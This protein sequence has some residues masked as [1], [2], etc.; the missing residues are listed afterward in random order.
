M[1]ASSDNK[2]NQDLARD[3]TDWAEDRTLM[4]NE[5]T[6]SSWVGTGLG[7]VGVAI[8]LKAVFGEFEPTWAAKAVA[9]LFLLAAIAIF[10][11]ARRQALKTFARLNNNDANVQ[12]TRSYTVLAVIM[13]L[14]TIG[15]GAILW[16]L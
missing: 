3:R 12:P 4:A 8:G 9:T 7:A 1:G 6:F 10:W 13:T 5:R 16:S 11:A 2:N 14:A 15:T